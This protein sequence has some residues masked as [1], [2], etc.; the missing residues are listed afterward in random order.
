MR[1]P[2]FPP[3]KVMK[4]NSKV[5]EHRRLSKTFTSV[6]KRYGHKCNKNYASKISTVSIVCSKKK[7]VDILLCYRYL[8]W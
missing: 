6:Y 2:E 3:K 5:L 7:I 8:Y 1:V 4:W